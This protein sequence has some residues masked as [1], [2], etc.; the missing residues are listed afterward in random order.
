MSLLQQTRNPVPAAVHCCYLL[1]TSILAE[2]CSAVSHPAMYV[3][4]S[5]HHTAQTTPPKKTPQCSKYPWNKNSCRQVGMLQS[6]VL[7]KPAHC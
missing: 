2:P 1:S 5:C 4:L 3:L 7:Y 6:P